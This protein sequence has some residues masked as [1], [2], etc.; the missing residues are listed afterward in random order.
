M[1]APS[2]DSDGNVEEDDGGLED[3]HAD[4]FLNHRLFFAIMA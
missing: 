3:R 2:F 1:V 4:Q